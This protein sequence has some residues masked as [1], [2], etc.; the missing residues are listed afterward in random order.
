MT[1]NWREI[2]HEGWRVTK[3]Y[4]IFDIRLT[5]KTSTIEDISISYE[6]IAVQRF[7]GYYHPVSEMTV[8]P[9]KEVCMTMCYLGKSKKTGETDTWEIPI[10]RP[11]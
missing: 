3:K 8:S 6:K 2:L 4:F 7:Y 1:E 5:D 9:E 11:E 10:E